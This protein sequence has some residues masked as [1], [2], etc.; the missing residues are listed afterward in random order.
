[1]LSCRKRMARPC[2]NR[3]RPL[4]S[5]G[6]DPMEATIIVAANVLPCKSRPHSL[7]SDEPA[8]SVTERET[9]ESNA[10]FIKTSLR[11]PMEKARKAALALAQGDQRDTVLQACYFL[12]ILDYALQER[13]VNTAPILR[14][15]E[16]FLGARLAR[17]DW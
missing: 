1:M 10:E 6:V 2:G 11:G 14:D 13:G 9:P 4:A 7:D 3:A 12:Q 15:I 16:T 8:P 5:K 17:G